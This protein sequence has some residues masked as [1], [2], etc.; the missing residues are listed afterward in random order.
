[1]NTTLKGLIMSFTKS[2]DLYNYLLKNH[3]R[4]TAIAAYYI[5]NTMNLS[6]EEMSNLV[7][8]AALHDIGALSLSERDALIQMDVE[9]PHPHSRLGC[10][11]L[12]SFEPFFKVS[13]ILYY[14]H[15]AYE[16]NNEWI[17]EVGQVPIQSY[18]LHV[19]DRIE[20][21]IRQDKPVLLQKQAIKEKIQ[22]YS[23]TLFHPDVVKAFQCAS[24]QDAFWLDIDNLDLNTILENAMSKELEIELTMDV[25]EQF[26]YTISK[27]IDCRSKFTISHSFGVSAVAY[28]LAGIMGYSEEKRRLIRVA[29]LLHD[30][31]K[32]AISP[33]I[34]EKTGALDSEERM[35]IQTHAYY[36][37]LI[38]KDIDG[39]GEISEWA[40]NHHE[41]H[42]G[43]GY[44]KNLLETGFT[45]E[46]DI[47]SYADI[48]TALSE[49][50]PYRSSLEPSQILSIL[51]SQYISK[52]GEHV[53]RIIE[54][55]VNK[56]D[57]VCKEAIR[58]GE[59]RFEIFTEFSK[60][61]F[62]VVST[63]Q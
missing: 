18:I 50:R 43:S 32:I 46:M 36:T 24:E 31:G 15:W 23:G 10:Y 30:M 12:E 38:L 59:N 49:N 44:P 22:S 58:D 27:I 37:Y 26:A 47:I 8:G 35:E 28:E 13:R 45:E 16:N 52:H 48:Y 7:I 61:Y 54:E 33:A 20:I 56:L 51:E 60:R 17:D 55:H 3:H 6:K 4:R 40:S 42:D 21:L 29:G 2:I 9:N 34:I 39:L 1:M 63:A 41:N 19:A 57:K 11:M 62:Q 14:H 53:F 5:G 25:L